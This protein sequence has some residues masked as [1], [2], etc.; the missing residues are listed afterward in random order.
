MVKHH[1]DYGKDK[2]VEVSKSGH[3]GMHHDA[4]QSCKAWGFNFLRGRFNLDPVTF[5]R[6]GKV[7]GC[8][9]WVTLCDNCWD[10]VLAIPDL[11]VEVL[12]KNTWRYSMEVRGDAEETREFVKEYIRRYPRKKVISLEDRLALETKGR[13]SD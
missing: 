9:H 6:N 1:T 8:G 13:G 10:K 7:Y 4:C 12:H 2:T 3:W 11:R 5:L